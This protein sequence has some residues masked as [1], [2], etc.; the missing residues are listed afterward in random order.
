[1]ALLLLGLLSDIISV[2]LRRAAYSG[3]SHPMSQCFFLSSW[4][5]FG[6]IELT[7]CIFALIYAPNKSLNLNPLV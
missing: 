6:D 3:Y 1:M 4:H 7:F 5:T 2:F